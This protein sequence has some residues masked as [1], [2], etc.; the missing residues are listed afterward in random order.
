MFLR[1][2]LWMLALIPGLAFAQEG[3]YRFSIDQDRLEGAPD[4]S[5]LNAPLT[6]ADRVRAEGGLFVT[7][8]GKRVRFFG[9][10][11]AFSANFPE[12]RDAERI[13]RRLRRLG[14]YCLFHGSKIIRAHHCFHIKKAIIFFRRLRIAEHHN[15]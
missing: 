4:H 2:M 12:A 11:L 1:R 5:F 6:E 13:A 8:A 15:R 3:Y 9:V 10:N 7:A 14:V